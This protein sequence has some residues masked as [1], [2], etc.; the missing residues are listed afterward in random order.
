VLPKTEPALSVS[1]E[2]S[3]RA[4]SPRVASTARPSSSDAAG[5]GPPPSCLQYDQYLCDHY[6]VSTCEAARAKTKS[7]AFDTPARRAA[8]EAHCAQLLR[9]AIDRDEPTR[10]G[11]K[12]AGAVASCAKMKEVSCTADILGDPATK[13]FCEQGDLMARNIALNTTPEQAE[14]SCAT[15]IRDLPHL[16]AQRRA[17]IA[18]DAAAKQDTLEK[19]GLHA[20]PAP[21]ASPASK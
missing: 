15:W 12:A 19:Y 7:L 21:Q 17:Q 8:G 2:V 18:G 20:M 14:L 5:E 3:S 11:M 13:P 10:S 1:S 4:S 16:V 6:G 9:E